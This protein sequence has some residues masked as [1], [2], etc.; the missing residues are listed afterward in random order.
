MSQGTSDERELVDLG[1][2]ATCSCESCSFETVSAIALI[3]NIMCTM[4]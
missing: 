2:L 4:S 3:V 1:E